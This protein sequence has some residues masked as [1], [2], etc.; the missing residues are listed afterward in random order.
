M[1]GEQ[2]HVKCPLSLP[3]L[4]NWEKFPVHWVQLA[5]WPKLLGAIPL[6]L[7]QR[8]PCIP[9]VLSVP[10]ARYHVATSRLGADQAA[11]MTVLAPGA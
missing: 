9:V 5:C 7:A 8:E 11:I 6:L 3:G 4:I 10:E 1:C 2:I